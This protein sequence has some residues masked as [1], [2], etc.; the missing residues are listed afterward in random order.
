MLEPP[1]IPNISHESSISCISNSKSRIELKE[2][3]LV[4]GGEFGRDMGTFT[5]EHSSHVGTST[6]HGHD[7]KSNKASGCACVCVL[8]CVYVW[9][10]PEWL[11]STFCVD[12]ETGKTACLEREVRK[13]RSRCCTAWMPRGST[14]VHTWV[15]GSKF[16][17]RMCRSSE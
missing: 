11:F 1:R 4:F 9:V 15:E 7:V 10:D 13:G 5:G 2:L 12:A 17:Q 16:T 6:T 3:C 8:A 14:L